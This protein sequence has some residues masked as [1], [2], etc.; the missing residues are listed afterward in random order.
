MDESGRRQIETT[1]HRLILPR[2]ANH[3]GTLY[4]GS[5]LSLA[6]EAGYAAAYQ[7]I[8]PSAN[9]V[10]KRVLD[11]R[12]F[13]PV[14]I[15]QVVEIRA[16][17]V[18]EAS[19]QIIIGLVGT[20]MPGQATPWMDGLMQFV[21]VDEKGRPVPIELEGVAGRERRKV[22]PW[23]KLASRAARLRGIRS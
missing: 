9:L 10:L 6:L 23:E 8:G 15:G 7:S 17:G 16:R 22:D 12:C 20:P 4:A 3:H 2:D 5:L 11:L 1:T 19:A 21:Q 18:F 13:H 14:P